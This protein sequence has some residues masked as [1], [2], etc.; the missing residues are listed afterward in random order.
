MFTGFRHHGESAASLQHWPPIEPQWIWGPCCWKTPNGCPTSSYSYP[1]RHWGKS[2]A[3]WKCSLFQYI[4][5]FT[6]ASCQLE[7]LR[8]VQKPQSISVPWS[9]ITIL[10]SLLCF[11]L[12][13]IW[14][15]SVA[16][17][18]YKVIQ[19]YPVIICPVSSL[20]STFNFSNSKSSVLWLNKEDTGCST[21]FWHNQT[22]IAF[23]FLLANVIKPVL[24]LEKVDVSSIWLTKP[25]FYYT[26][27]I[28]DWL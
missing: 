10:N 15:H 22:L 27:S 2:A 19:Q 12:V 17:Y 8:A 9:L 21:F 4:G 3:A 25:A 5:Y 20:F 14:P 1:C 18:K 28:W 11:S 6:T 24:V 23:V 13:S 16:G 7:W 26:I